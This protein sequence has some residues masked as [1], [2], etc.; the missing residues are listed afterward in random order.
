MIADPP[1]S[2]LVQVRWTTPAATADS[3][4]RGGTVAV[5]GVS[6]T[7]FDRDLHQRRLSP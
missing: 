2:E 4:G 3:I 7:S 6:A 1:S 5:V